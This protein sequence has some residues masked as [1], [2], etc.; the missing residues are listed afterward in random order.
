MVTTAVSLTVECD[1]VT[2]TR[3]TQYDYP[4]DSFQPVKGH[5]NYIEATLQ[6]QSTIITAKMFKLPDGEF[7]IQEGK[8]Y[9]VTIEEV[10]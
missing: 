2:H 3:S 8:T 10:A 1:T 7:P 9:R 5:V 4:P 6:D